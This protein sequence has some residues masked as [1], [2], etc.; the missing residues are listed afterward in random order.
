MIMVTAMIF[1]SIIPFSAIV[2]RFRHLYKIIHIKKKDISSLDPNGKVRVIC[3][4][5]ICT[6]GCHCLTH[7]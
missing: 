5:S 7:R 4:Q 1:I 3:N 6:L 2:F